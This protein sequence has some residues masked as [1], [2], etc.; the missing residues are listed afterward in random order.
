MEDYLS[1]FDQRGAVT[2]VDVSGFLV[3][4][5]RKEYVGGVLVYFLG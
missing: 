3:R 4:I 5:E 1:G 2:H